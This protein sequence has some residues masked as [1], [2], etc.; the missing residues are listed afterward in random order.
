MNIFFENCALCTLYLDKVYTLSFKFVPAEVL[1]VATIIEAINISTCRNA[2]MYFPLVA[3]QLL[4][5]NAM[6]HSWVRVF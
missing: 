4:R 3:V 5:S 1:Y 6:F 2:V